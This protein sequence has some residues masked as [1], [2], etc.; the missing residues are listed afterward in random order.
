MSQQDVVTTAKV[1]IVP[2]LYGSGPEHWQSEW[3]KVQPEFRRVEQVEWNGPSCDDWVRVLDAAILAED[4]KVILVGHS[5]GSVTIAH[6][7]FR[8]GRR[9]VGALLVAP[10]DTEAA[11]FPAGTSGFAPIPTGRLPFPSIVVASTED[12]YMSFERSKTLAEA[13]GSEFISIGAK[14]HISASDGFGPW[15]D[16]LRYIAE[17]EKRTHFIA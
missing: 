12:P 8:Y 13:W 6:W 14:G 3:E 11:S 17:L 5:L 15:P 4:D 16:G 7:A 9:I 2:G 1:L 10:S